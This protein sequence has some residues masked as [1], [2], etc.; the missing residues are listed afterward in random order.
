MEVDEAPPPPDERP[1]PQPIDEDTRPLDPAEETVTQAQPAP[2]VEPAASARPKGSAEVAPPAPR[3]EP[4]GGDDEY[5]RPP[6]AVPGPG[7]IPGAGGP[8]VWQVLPGSGGAGRAK[9]PAAPTTTPKRKID[10]KA[11]ERALDAGVRKKD[12]KLGLDFPAASA[13]AS[14]VRSTVRGSEAPYT[15]QAGFS[16]A[17][18]AQGGV[19]SV[20][21]IHHQGG[22][23]ALWNGI[24]GRVLAALSARTFPMRSSF[25]KGAI[26]SVTVNSTKRKPSGGAGRKGLGFSFDPSNIG[27]RE[28]RFVTVGFSAQPVR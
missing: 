12:Q 19:R 5:D 25:A 27:A 10:K 8:A 17:L 2:F 1:A 6:P 13:I 21:L 3:G 9:G 24:K 22:S 28:T 18:N 11:A 14:I 26:V 23:A 7:G 20:S 16:I 4:K 15:C